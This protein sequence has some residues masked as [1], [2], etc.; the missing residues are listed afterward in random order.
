MEEP[1]VELLEL[2]DLLMEEHA[3]ELGA[4][5]ELGLELLELLDLLM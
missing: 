1:A 2:L 3:V 5:E 4:L